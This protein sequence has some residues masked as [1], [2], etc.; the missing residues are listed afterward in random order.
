MVANTSARIDE[1]EGWPVLVLEG[2]P[3]CV[4]AVDRNGVLDFHLPYRTTD[5]VDVAFERELGGM[6]PNHERFPVLARPGANI[7]QRAQPVDAGVGPEVDETTLPA[8]L[9]DVRRGEL[10][11]SAAPP[12]AASSRGT[13]S[14]VSA[15]PAAA[16]AATTLAEAP[17]ARRRP[18]TPRRAAAI[19]IAAVPRKRRRPWSI[20]IT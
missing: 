5:V 18:N 19:V 9:D 7:W 1:V 6:Y 15:V 2:A 17:P 12:S 4:L 20:S 8:R 10:S 16:T 13:R 3:D 11:H 14:F